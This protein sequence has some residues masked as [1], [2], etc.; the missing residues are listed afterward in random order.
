MIVGWQFADHM[1]TDL[2]LDA[3]RMALARRSPGADARR[4]GLNDLDPRPRLTNRR[5]TNSP[6]AS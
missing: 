3:L 5:F 2:V 6:T 4:Q 1:R